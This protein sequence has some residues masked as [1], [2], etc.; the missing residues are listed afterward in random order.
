M[1]ARELKHNK[2][3]GAHYTSQ[4]R[5]VKI[6][7]F[8]EFESL[9][10]ARKRERH[11]KGWIKIKKRTLLGMVIRLSFKFFLKLKQK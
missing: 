11:I 8:E 10:E 2:E 5:S 3:E 6:V 4:R 1:A 7:Y 9:V